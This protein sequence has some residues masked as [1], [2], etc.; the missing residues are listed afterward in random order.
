MS[1]HPQLSHITLNAAHTRLHCPITRFRSASKHC[2]AIFAQPPYLHPSAQRPASASVL[3]LVK[4]TIPNRPSLSTRTTPHRTL[5]SSPVRYVQAF[6]VISSVAPTPW[7]PPT[8][9]S[10]R[11]RTELVPSHTIVASL[12]C[13]RAVTLQIFL[14]LPVRMFIFIGHLSSS[15]A[16][17][18]H[19][20]AAQLTINTVRP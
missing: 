2:C 7:S 14:S 4:A 6:Q 15:S 3:R 8:P 17:A 20:L 18:I 10:R 16:R 1:T 12:F 5:L 19:F 9:F 13:I 11:N